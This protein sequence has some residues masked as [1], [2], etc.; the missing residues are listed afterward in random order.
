MPPAQVLHQHHAEHRDQHGL[1]CGL[2]ARPTRAG[3]LEPVAVAVPD[4][5]APKSVGASAI[6]IGHGG[7]DFA[8]FRTVYGLVRPTD[9]G[10]GGG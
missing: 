7:R 10:A 6:W 1:H 5:T 8:T 9:F 4:G 3:S 2:T